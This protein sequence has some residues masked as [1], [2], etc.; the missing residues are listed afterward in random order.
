M[1]N[2]ISVSLWGDSPIYCLGAIKNAQLVHKMLPKWIYRVFYDSSVPKVY[3]DRLSAIPSVS[4][5]EVTQ[6]AGNGM[7]WRFYSAF[8]SE[9][10]IVL[11]RDTDSRL[12]QREVLCI[13]QFLD[14]DK[15]FSVIKDHFRHYEWPMLGGMWGVK[16]QLPR[17]LLEP[18]IHY[19]KIS[20]YGA[21]QSFLRDHV[22][23]IAS[24]S[25]MIH[26]F[27]DNSWMMNTRQPLDFI[28]Q[29]YDEFDNPLYDS[30]GTRIVP[31]A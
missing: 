1:A 11:S 12:S 15:T 16:G 2:I 10:D 31:R 4:L 23:P 20:K 27:V 17:G 21:D 5:V 29:G 28:G 14:S 18:M 13:Y 26:G 25:C 24:N 8:Q 22:W 19:S 6:D 3:L 7:F 30:N 9:C